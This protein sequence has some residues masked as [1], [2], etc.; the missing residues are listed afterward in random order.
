MIQMDVAVWWL[1]MHATEV[2]SVGWK[3]NYST[4][5]PMG[6]LNGSAT[7]SGPFVAPPAYGQW[8]VQNTLVYPGI[9][10]LAD[11]VIRL[12]IARLGPAVAQDTLRADVLFLG[13][14]VSKSRAGTKGIWERS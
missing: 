9:E 7:L 10:L 14:T 6:A 12:D 5:T 3:M 4:L 1:N 11:S 2:G 8:V 13:A